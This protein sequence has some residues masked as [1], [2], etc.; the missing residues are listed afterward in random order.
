MHVGIKYFD[1]TAA[2]GSGLDKEYGVAR[3]MAGK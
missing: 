3:E 1:P 2:T